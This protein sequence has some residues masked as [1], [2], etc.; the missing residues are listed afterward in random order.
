[1]TAAPG[2]AAFPTLFSP[3]RIGPVEVRNRI[4]ITAHGT[5][6]A[7]RH[8]GMSPASYIE[9]LRR[10]AAGGAGLII[11]QPILSDPLSSIT[12]E[13]IDRHGRLVEAVRAEGAT[14]LLQ[15]THLGAFARSEADVRRPPL[16]GFDGHPVRGGRDRA[17]D[18]GRRD[19]ADDR[20]LPADRGDGRGGGLRRG[21]GARGARLPRPAVAHPGV[22]LPRRRMGPRPHAVRPA[23]AR[24]RPG[25]DGPGPDRRLPHANRRPALARGRRHRV[26]AGS[27]RSSAPCWAPARSTCSTPRSGTAAPAT[28]ARSPTTATARRP[29][30]RPSPGCAGRCRSTCR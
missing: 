24:R 14:F 10:R 13:T 11:C 30:S 4:V 22:Q 3:I 23:G 27:P 21:R 12:A 7:F 15:L 16:L 5:S 29:T 9:Y 26:R 20:G 18:D 25:R 2:E 19:R 28:R 8:P 6:E 1:M 17:P